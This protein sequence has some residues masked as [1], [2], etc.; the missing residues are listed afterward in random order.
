M[1]TLA[2]NPTRSPPLPISFEAAFTELLGHEGG[3]TCH[4]SDPGGATCWGVTERVA[5]AHGY[6]GP[7]QA[8]P[9]ATAL[10]IYRADYWAPVRAAE[11]PAPLRY[12]MFDAAVNSGVRQSVL[13]L[14][15]AA[16]VA[17]DGVLGP[18]TLAAVCAAEPH[19]LARRILGQRLDFM[20]HLPTWS[21]FGRGWSIRIGA[22]LQAA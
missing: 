13:W 6:T 9:Q 12:L 11:L 17:D 3:Y 8:L 20:A 5:R 4:P 10:A 15:R 2:E 14:Q 16:G 21:A 19:V 1:P 22:L 7:M 18:V